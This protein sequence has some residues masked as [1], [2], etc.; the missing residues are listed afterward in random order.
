[1][2]HSIHPSKNFLHY[3]DFY[4]PFLFHFSNAHVYLSVI[5]AN[6]CA[7]G[8]ELVVVPTTDHLV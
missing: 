6:S 4:H 2:N 7:H 8:S 3:Y 5:T 1:M